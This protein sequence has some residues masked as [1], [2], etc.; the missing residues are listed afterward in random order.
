MTKEKIL[1][2]E[3]DIRAAEC[4]TLTLQNENYHVVHV[5]TGAD[6][7]TR[8][9]KDRPD[10]ILMNMELPDNDGVE[11][12]RLISS[13]HDVPIVFM[14]THAKKETIDLAQQVNPYGYLIKP[15]PESQLLAS[16]QIICNLKQQKHHLER[17][18]KETENWQSTI[19]NNIADAIVVVDAAAKIS[20]MNPIAQK[21][22]GYHQTDVLRKPINM[23]EILSIKTRKPIGFSARSG[24]QDRDTIFGKN[25]AILISKDKSEIFIEYKFNTYK[26]FND[27]MVG[28]VLVFR[29]ISEHMA[30]KETIMKQVAQL[31][32]ER[33]ELLI[34][35][36][37]VETI[38]LGLTI[39][40]GAGK[41]RY[42]NPAEARMHGYEVEQLIGQP[43]K[44]FAPPDLWQN[45]PS[46]R[47]DEAKSWKRDSINVRKDGTRFPAQLL[48]VPV[49]DTD[50]SRI[51]I[52][53]ICEDITERKKMTA[54]LHESERKLRQRVEAIERDMQAAQ[55]IQN[56]LLPKQFPVYDRLHIDYRYYPLETTG[57][58][59]FSFVQLQEGG[60]GIF[61]GDVAS[62]GVRAALFLSLI[63]ATTD[64]ICR[65]FGQKPIDYIQNL[66]RAL[67][68]NMPHSYL[69]GQYGF[70]Q[71]GQADTEAT[72]T[73]CNG[74]HPY[75]ILYRSSSGTVDYIEINGDLLGIFNN[76]SFV[77]KSIS[78]HQGDRIFFYTDGVPET[79]NVDH[80][81]VGDQGF[82][83]VIKKAS[84][85]KLS[86][87]LDAITTE[88]NQFRGAA[89]IEDDFVLIGMEYR[90]G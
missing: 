6:A 54:A 86:D 75:P 74:G 36:K 30:A 57:G 27:K 70:Y 28:F 58:D 9:T 10:L 84:K 59:Y 24:N 87:T 14:A 44:I 46:L 29:D 15:I 83:Q 43:T 8:V 49:T 35:K 5:N 47:V 12:A 33:K 56:E 71:F 7:L 23:L 63:K 69:T 81:Q 60:F 1:I 37:A 90:T 73:V 18:L 21:L 52:I 65:L 11:L 3:D 62:H 39:S 64:R 66:N 31:E 20:F 45:V 2:V 41:I 89:P 53:T 16:V 61:I 77:E 48:S 78:L 13:K 26:G 19:L 42:T 25:A 51:G 88:I 17:Q 40:D 4:L 72:L 34:L 50:G 55:M 80:E 22:T 68:N 67:L 76:A 82:L 32:T 85:E 38:D 79:S